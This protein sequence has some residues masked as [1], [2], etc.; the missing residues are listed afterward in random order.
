MWITVSDGGRLSIRNADQEK[1]ITILY[2]L[3]YL[4]AM[5]SD[6]DKE[7]DKER[8]RRKDQYFLY[9]V[10]IFLLNDTSDLSDNKNHR[11]LSDPI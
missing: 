4:V 11:G 8:E 5:I 10:L 6:E 9:V 1:K 3:L 7:K 2:M